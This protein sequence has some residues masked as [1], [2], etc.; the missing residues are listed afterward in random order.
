L[1]RGS[2]CSKGDHPGKECVIRIIAKDDS[3][4]DIIGVE[5]LDPA[6]IEFDQN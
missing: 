4:K 1:T 5:L 2:G 3:K 6:I